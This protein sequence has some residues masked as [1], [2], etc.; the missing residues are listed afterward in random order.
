MVISVDSYDRLEMTDSDLIIE[1]ALMLV[2]YYGLGKWPY[3]DYL[4]GITTFHTDYGF[5]MNN[6][7]Q[8]AYLSTESVKLFRSDF[9][10]VADYLVQARIRNNHQLTEEKE[11]LRYKPQGGEIRHLEDFAQVMTALSGDE[12]FCQNATK[13]KENSEPHTDY[14]GAR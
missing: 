1:P 4:K 9:R 12:S 6:G 2:L 3:H 11:S 13:G 5:N 14:S 10:F 7:F 8:M